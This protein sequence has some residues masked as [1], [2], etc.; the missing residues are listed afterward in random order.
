MVD[1]PRDTMDI[2]DE[3]DEI[4]MMGTNKAAPLVLGKLPHCSTAA[5]L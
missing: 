1:F 3:E 4:N 5:G 2:S